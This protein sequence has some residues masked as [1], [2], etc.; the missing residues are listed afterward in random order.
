MA[1]L[2]SNL[3]IR[4]SSVLED[5]ATE[6]HKNEAVRGAISGEAG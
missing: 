1:S 3:L 4:S 6:P 5:M 2:P